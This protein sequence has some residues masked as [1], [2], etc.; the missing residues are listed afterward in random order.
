MPTVPTSETDP[1]ERAGI[2]PGTVR[3]AGLLGNFWESMFGQPKP[4]PPP[5]GAPEDMSLKAPQ[6]DRTD[7]PSAYEIQETYGTPL[8]AALRGGKMRAM[9]DLA[10]MQQGNMLTGAKKGIQATEDYQDILKRAAI[11]SDRSA[12]AKLG[13]SPERTSVTPGGAGLNVAGLF[14]PETGEKWF[15]PEYPET[16]IH[17]GFHHG[18]DVLRK[19]DMLPP[20]VAVYTEEYLVRAMVQRHL[21]DIESKLR[22]APGRGGS[23]EQQIEAGKR[24]PKAILDELEVAAMKYLGRRKGPH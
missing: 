10:V 20:R 19:A 14:Q 9:S 24:V 23:A 21:G 4:P 3:L 17:E 6:A 1:Y 16:I 13:F 2:S 5:P 18:I 12:L 22:Y 15:D 7:M 8:E 11:I